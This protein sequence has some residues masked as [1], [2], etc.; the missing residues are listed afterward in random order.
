MALEPEGA[1]PALERFLAQAVGSEGCRIVRLRR[2]AGGTVQD[3]WD[4]EISGAPAGVPERLVLRTG[5]VVGVKDSLP[6]AQ[7]YAVLCA[8]AKA[9]VHVPRPVAVCTD[10]AVIGQPFFLMAFVE[11]ESRP[12]KLQRMPEVMA[13]GDAILEE[14]G[15][16]LA[17]LQTVAPAADHG[18]AFLKPP[19]RDVAREAIAEM[20]AYLDAH[21]HPHPAIEYALRWLERHAPAPGPVVLCHGDFRFGNVII[22]GTTLAAVLD[23]EL[24]RWGDPYES[25]AWFC[26]RFF[27]FGRP[28]LVGGGLGTRAALLRGWQAVSGRVP[29]PDAIRYWDVMASTRWAVISLQQVARQVSGGENS[30]E[31]ALVGLGTAEMEME[32]LSRIQWAGQ[33]GAK[34]KA[35]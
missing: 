15:A 5:R 6:A 16:E 12:W 26:M 27:R 3:N 22:A 25:M 21:D 29:D 24:T 8:A 14:I 34:R 31:L 2:L 11:G 1:R 17:R 32:A 33:T 20:R 18:L 10:P 35:A 28:D 30:L 23:W 7:E 9:G 13:A 4:V 19:P